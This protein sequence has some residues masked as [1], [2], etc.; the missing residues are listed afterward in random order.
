MEHTKINNGNSFSLKNGMFEEG[1]K[2]WEKNYGSGFTAVQGY[3]YN[4]NQVKALT[5]NP[6]GKKCGEE[7]GKVESFP[8]CDATYRILEVMH[9]K[10]SAHLQSST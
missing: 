10:C 8:G 9:C 5:A 2:C 7:L 4:K 6:Q 1:E 3:L